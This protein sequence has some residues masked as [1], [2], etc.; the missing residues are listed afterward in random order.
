MVMQPNESAES[1]AIRTQRRILM[2]S[3]NILF[4][5]KALILTLWNNAIYV[6]PTYERELFIKDIFY[7]QKKGYIEIT[8]NPMKTSSKLDEKYILLT[9]EGKEIAEQTMTDPALK[10]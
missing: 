6:E 8:T 1:I 4:P 3:L 10:I 2:Q 9:A 7:L 5:R